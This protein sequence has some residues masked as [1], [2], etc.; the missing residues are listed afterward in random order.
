MSVSN[1]DHSDDAEIRELRNI[2]EQGIGLRFDNI[3][4]SG[5]SGNM[6]GIKS[7]HILFSQRLDS[8]TF[9]VKDD[10]YGSS[11]EAG[12]FQG[13]HAEH[14][15]LG[16]MTLNKLGIPT[17]EILDEKVIEEKTQAAELQNGAQSIRLADVQKGRTLVRFSRQIDRF[18]IWSSS[19]IFGFTKD[20]QIG[21]MQAHWPEIPKY[22]VK[23]VHRLAHKL[24]R[25]WSA[26]EIRGASVEAVE[27]GI[28]HSPAI[29]FFMDIY[30]VIRVI[31]RPDVA[32]KKP[33]LYFDRDAKNVPLPRQIEWKY[34]EKQQKSTTPQRSRA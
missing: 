34:E 33:V 28:I 2:A 11:R 3:L 8:R 22:T 4:E 18:P 12:I 27:A 1:S 30:P 21:F 24:Q 19:S 10:R 20:K 6:K 29:A 25:G 23:E 17:S 5:S 14:L 7:D 15:E 16:R 26:P 13:S 31:Y 32:G 9:F